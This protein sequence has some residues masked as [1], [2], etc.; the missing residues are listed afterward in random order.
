MGRSD[1]SGRFGD[2]DHFDGLGQADA[3]GDLL[4][5]LFDEHSPPG[6]ALEALDEFTLEDSQT[7][8]LVLR[9]TVGNLDNANSLTA[10]HRRKWYQFLLMHGSEE[11]LLTLTTTNLVLLRR[12]VK[13]RVANSPQIRVF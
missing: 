4:P 9:P 12:E 5:V 3:D 11:S 7:D 8:Q 10:G 2:E 13:S 6:E 1:I